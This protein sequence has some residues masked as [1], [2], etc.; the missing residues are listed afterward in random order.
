MKE[1]VVA[2]DF[3]KS[4]IQALQY[5]AKISTACGCS[6]KMVYVS[7]ARDKDW[8]I[9]KD[10]KGME[11]SIANSFN[12]LLQDVPGL[13]PGKISYKILLG[14]IYEEIT[15]QAKYTDAGLIIAGAH[16][17]S[18]FEEEWIGNN[19]L[20]IIFHAEKP[21]IV[22]KK[23][24]RIKDPLIEKIILPIDSTSETLLKVPFTVK[25]AQLFKA[26]INVLSLVSSKIKNI[27]EKVE[28]NTKAAMDLII[29]TG[30][31]YINERKVSDNL[32]KAIIDYS[33]KRNGDLISLMTDQEYTSGH[34]ISN[35]FAQ[36]TINNSPVP[37][38]SI[39]ANMLQ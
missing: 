5:A 29:P 13:N 4:S 39:R 18:G 14:K 30:L 25:L 32:S 17:M 26:Q 1:I 31:R 22:V 23:T 11:L 15:N 21:V 34:P 38:L 16:G 6:I 3:S 24:F 20:K 19:A 10:E 28:K 8:N 12:K 36:Q 35:I 33:V 9:V 37:I 27:E 2:V 7:K